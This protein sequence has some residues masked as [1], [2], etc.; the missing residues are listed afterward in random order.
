MRF[1]TMLEYIEENESY[2]VVPLTI[3]IVKII[4]DFQNID[5][6]DRV[7]MATALITDSVLVSKDKE[8]GVSGLNVICS[9]RDSTFPDSY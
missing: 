9:R 6:H 3:R 7:I 2:K 8:I 4:R 5:L 1:D